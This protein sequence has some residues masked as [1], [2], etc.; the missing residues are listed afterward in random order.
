MRRSF[1]WLCLALVFLLFQS[2]HGQTTEN[3][4][5][6]VRPDYFPVATQ[7]S[8]LASGNGWTGQDGPLDQQ[9]LRDTVEN[10]RQHGFTGLE[11]HIDGLPESEANYLRGHAVE[12]GMFLVAHTGG[13]EGFGRDT[14]PDPSV[15]SPEYIKT[16]R[17]RAEK[18]LAWTKDPQQAKGLQYVFTFQDEPFHAGPDSFGH[19]E[20]EKQEFKRR[21]GYDLPDD[22]ESVRDDPQRWLDVL[23]FHSDNYA[24][25]WRQT[26]QAIKATNPNF[27]AILTHDSHNTF[28]GGCKSNAALAVDDVFHWGGD[29]ADMFVFDIYP[30]MMFDFRF[31]KPGQSPK[32]RM[33]QAHYSFAQMRNLTRTFDKQFG[34][35]VGTYNPAWFKDYM[36]EERLATYWSERVMST[37]AVAAGA[38]FLLTGYKL[39]IDAAHWES[40]GE[41]LRLIQKAGGRLLDAPR[42][43]AKACM[44]FPRT[45]YLQVQEEYF[46]V[47]LSYELFL[48]AFG[49]LDVLHEEQIVDDRLDG[50]EVVVLFDVKLL[51]R[52]VAERLASF[53]ANGGTLIADCVPV[54]DE[55][56]RPMETMEKLFGV[57]EANTDRIAR[58]GHWV[59]RTA[60]PYWFARSEGSPE[61]TPQRCDTLEGN[62]WDGS[63]STRLVSTR[64]CVPTDGTVLLKTASGKPGLIRHDVG[65]G[66][67][68]LLGF[69]LQDTYFQMWEE[70]NDA[71][72]DDLRKLLLAMTDASGVHAHV[73]SSN[74]EVEAAVR[75]NNR[76]GFLFLINHETQQPA[77]TVRLVDLPFQIGTILDL[78]D[79]KP[80]SFRE[81]QGVLELDAE[82]PL[83]E[84]RLLH[85]LPK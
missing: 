68:F 12:Q 13:L 33:S 66:H 5:K 11:T 53:V 44:I 31:G 62:V 41:G 37:S 48:R 64:E 76:E 52:K 29:F 63:Y 8:P 51:P 24:D 72:R 80:V 60:A 4:T 69:C 17:D 14:P 71:G 36:G 75:V 59:P 6:K 54:M 58:T 3:V 20:F 85:V 30:Y 32:P 38:D 7:L 2:V 73:R 19:G 10:L 83:G 82:V 43:K 39:P 1:D 23:N 56:R 16:I 26:Y 78:A 25:G 55:H 65:R 34:F 61:E 49:E 74:P 35:W 21:Y 57:K 77:T 67:A 22:P 27:T 9:T 45:Q 70:E 28:G 50:Y 79:G 47:A 18:A 40:F 81:D 84:T 15:F 42:I 46:N